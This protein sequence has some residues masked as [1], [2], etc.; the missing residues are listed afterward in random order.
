VTTTHI[1]GAGLAGLSAAVALASKAQK[2]VVYE[3]ADQAGGRCRS[4]WDSR[5][6]RVIDNGNHLI[7]SGNRAVL[8]YLDEIG[9]RDRLYDAGAARF[10]FLDLETGER[11]ELR[12]GAGRLPFWILDKSR[13][14]AGTGIGDYLSLDLWRLLRAGPKD[15]VEDCLKCEGV[16]WRRFWQPLI[17]AALNCE[18]RGASAALLKRVFRETFLAGAEAC[19]PLIARESLAHCL[20]EP[21]LGTLA[22]HGHEVRFNRRLRTMENDGRR[23]TLLN[24]GEDR[25]PIGAGDRVILALPPAGAAA[26]LP[27]LR[28]PLESSAIVNAHFQLPEQ[29]E[30]PQGEPRLLGLI[31]GT[32]DWIFLRDGMASITVSAADALVRTAA[33][34]IAA[35]LWRD[36]AKALGLPG[37]PLPAHRIIKEKRATFTQSPEGLALRAGPVTEFANLRL[38]GDWLDTGYPATIE[39][40]VRA[41]RWA[42]QNP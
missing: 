7:L 36:T 35:L 33:G 23:I 3:A 17:V 5:L 38:A 22:K 24:F 9:A 27:G 28:V 32:A 42:A 6:G 30:P 21:A 40:A 11:W 1:I 29:R 10:P 2:V 34:E 16:L 8:G 19:R 15:R 4:Y 39:S 20:V 41:G 13:R 25:Q 26:L 14:V 37:D 31:G 12:P 18:A